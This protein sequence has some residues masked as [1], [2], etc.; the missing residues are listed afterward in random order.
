MAANKILKI[1]PQY[2]AVAAANLLNGA[3]GSLAGPVGFTATQPYLILKHIHVSNKD[4][5][6]HAITL[7]IGATGGSAGG[8][9]FAWNN[10]SLGAQQYDDWF[11]Q[12]RLD[13]TDF[14]S[15][16]ADLASKVTIEIDAE[17]GFS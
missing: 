5:I 13:S 14:L 9:E 6:A 12:Q 16:I 15:G 11:G 10:F 3:L 4:T 17:I 7:Y 2:I 1:P 8:T